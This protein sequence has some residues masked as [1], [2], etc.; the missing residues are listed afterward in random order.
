MDAKG[1]E[2]PLEEEHEKVES[3]EPFDLDELLP[4]IGEFGRYQK[5]LLWLIC[6]PA[7]IPCGFCAFNQL[8]MTDVPEDYW[9]KIPELQNFSV[10]ERKLYGIPMVERDGQEEFSKCSRY[11]VDWKVLLADNDISTIV[12]NSSWPVELCRNGWEYNNSFVMSSIVI[13]YNLVCEYDIYPTLGL[14]ALNTGGPIGVY[15]FGMLNDRAGRRMAYFCCLAT[16]LFGS[17]ITAAS[18][19]FWMWAFSRVIVG[20]TIPAVYQIP[21]IIALELVGPNYRSF[22]TVMTCTFYTFGLMMLAGVT[23]LI[24]DWVELT[25]YTSVPFLLY[26]LYLFIM[27]ESPRWLL[28]KGKLEEALKI[29]E[30]MAKVNGK[31]FPAAFKN[32]LQMR[33]EAEKCRTVKKEEVS[34]GAFDLC[35]TPNMRLK[36][37]LITLNWFVNETVYLGLSYYG[38]SLGENQYLSFFLS[39]LVEIPS[40]V[41]CWI[42]MDRYGRRWPMCML[43]ILGGIS[44]VA[45]VVL[46]EDAVMETLFL[47]LLS[48]SMISASF[49]IIYPFAG[50]LYPTQVRGVGIGTSSYIGGLGLIVIPFITYLGKE[51]LVL[52]L[53]IMGCVSVAGGFT[54]LRL[55]E[56]LHHRLPQTLEEGEL[57]GQDWTFDDC[58]RCIPTK[59]SPTGSYEN[60]SQ[61]PSDTALELNRGEPM[62]NGNGTGGS[63]GGGGASG[64]SRSTASGSG[65][66][67]E[68][69]TSTEKTPLEIAR[70]RRKSMKRLVRQASTM[71]TQKTAEGAMQLTYWF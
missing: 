4:A 68:G 32:K 38:P 44:C 61:E 31:Q 46:P 41:V 11:A 28:M 51:N 39:S 12:P 25:L 67:Y 56:T 63:G 55:P 71:D 37:I 21:F 43:M 52:P 60:L 5:L 50:E 18:S 16:L 64:G 27:P 2:D 59:K 33:V 54:G 65:G 13:D 57:F 17:F 69:A 22:G 26:F 30:K 6:L 48:K 70:L 66:G 23:Y 3:E 35:R 10:Q 15:L 19:S 49:L 47:Y 58:F 1:S 14:V 53:V 24:R 40:Y 8:F 34:I 20:L 7:C 9:C 36:T 62:V 45:T 42:I 29:L